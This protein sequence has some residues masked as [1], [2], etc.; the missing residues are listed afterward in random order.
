MDWKNQ[1][2]D[3]N[4]SI[5]PLI[6]KQIVLHIQMEFHTGLQDYKRALAKNVLDYLMSQI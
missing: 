4:L 3:P 5:N 2:I 1:L 6:P